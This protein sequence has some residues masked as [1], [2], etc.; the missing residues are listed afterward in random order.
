MHLSQAEPHLLQLASL[1]LS[2]LCQRFQFYIDYKQGYWQPTSPAEEWNLSIPFI[3]SNSYAHIKQPYHTLCTKGMVWLYKTSPCRVSNIIFYYLRKN[4]YSS[5]C[6]LCNLFTMQIYVTK[7]MSLEVILLSC[8]LVIGQC[9]KTWELILS[10]YVQNFVDFIS[11][12]C[13]TLQ[14]LYNFRYINKI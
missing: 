1:R 10:L 5:Q 4:S 9:V 13:L 2:G 6:S 8:I 14:L 11:Q 3:Y 12:K 7:G